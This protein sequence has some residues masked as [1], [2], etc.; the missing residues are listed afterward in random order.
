MG[1]TSSSRPTSGYN[2]RSEL[3]GDT[4][5]AHAA[6]E[7]DGFDHSEAPTHGSAYP[8][9]VRLNEALLAIHERDARIRELMDQVETL[10]SSRPAALPGGEPLASNEIRVAPGIQA[11]I[12]CD[13][14]QDQTSF[15]Q[16]VAQTRS[17]VRWHSVSIGSPA[18]AS[19]APEERRDARRAIELEVVF[20]PETQFYTGL[21]QDISSGGVFIATYNTQPVGTLLSLSFELPCGTM[22]SA[23]GE[24]RWLRD[25]SEDIR[26]GMGVA[27]ISLAEESKTAI[28][29]FC[30][31]SPSLYMEI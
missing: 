30:E 25:G 20:E 14:I 5:G 15:S 12:T 24:V 27:F 13:T 18:R 10:T 1:S 11:S 3:R 2:L 31:A 21:T 7:V 6:A 22:V 16:N 28:E 19:I 9:E 29:H 26:P 23:F 17:D 4:P 8:L